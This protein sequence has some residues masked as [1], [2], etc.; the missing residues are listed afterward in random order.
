MSVGCAR[1]AGDGKAFL[2]VWGCEF[3]CFS[4]ACLLISPTKENLTAHHL[5]ALVDVGFE[6][7]AVWENGRYMRAFVLRFQLLDMLLKKRS[8]GSRDLAG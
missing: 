4:S 8:W 7:N 2:L 3:G 5:L 1:R 6:M